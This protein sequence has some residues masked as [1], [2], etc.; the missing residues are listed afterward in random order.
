MVD[1][2]A[3]GFDAGAVGLDQRLPRVLDAVFPAVMVAVVVG[4]AV[5]Q[6]DQQLGAGVH[7]VQQLRQVADRHAHARVIL[8]RDAGDAALDGTVIGFVEALDAEDFTA[9]AGDS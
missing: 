4:L 3:E 8:R 9:L 1:G 6:R 5:R 2:D 7:V